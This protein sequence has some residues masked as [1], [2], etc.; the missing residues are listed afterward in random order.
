MTV[1]CASA[2]AESALK[3][4]SGTRSAWLPEKPIL[5]LGKSRRRKARKKKSSAVLMCTQLPTNLVL[6]NRRLR[7]VSDCGKCRDVRSILYCL[8]CIALSAIFKE[9]DCRK[10]TLF[11]YAPKKFLFAVPGRKT[12]TWKNRFLP[13]SPQATKLN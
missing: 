12:L 2:K 5:Y 13:L 11:Q 3:I 4:S 8:P 1:R 10:K 6:C 7:K 9:P